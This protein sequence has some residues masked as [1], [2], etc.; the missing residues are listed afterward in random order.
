[1]KNKLSYFIIFLT[2]ALFAALY[3]SNY[4]INSE[5]ENTP[6]ET[7]IP[8]EIVIYAP[9]P[10][11]QIESPY[12]VLGTARGSW[13]FEAVFPINLKDDKG[14]VI[15]TAQANAISDWMTSEFVPFEA[16]LIFKN[17]TSKTG[18][19]VFHNDNPS[20]LPEN[21]KEFTMPV[22]FKTGGATKTKTI[23][24]Y[25][26]NKDEDMKLGAGNPT[27]GKEAVLPV[28]RTVPVSISPIKDTVN[29]LLEG[30][31]SNEEK[32][33]GF[34]TEFPNKDFKLIGANLKDGVATLAFN[35]VPGFTSGGSCRVGILWAQIE[36]TVLQFDG[37]KQVKFSPETLF[38]P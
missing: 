34:S 10:N 37:V 32:T 8:E 14:N 2:L 3:Y 36:K 28:E 18:T 9:Q 27:C 38:Q 26:Y 15:A 29:L 4:L 21:D 35:D 16:E 33:A 25:Y 20:G 1:M 19:L 31:I 6:K 30:K 13:F 5:A 23:K 24:L 17:Q 11:D 7:G 12:R 22:T